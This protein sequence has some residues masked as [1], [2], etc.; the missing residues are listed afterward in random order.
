MCTTLSSPV[1]Y[2]SLAVS[3]PFV[4]FPPSVC[5]ACQSAIRIPYKYK[6]SCSTILLPPVAPA[7]APPPDTG[8]QF[9]W[10]QY[11]VQLCSGGGILK[12][13]PPLSLSPTLH[14]T[15]GV[16]PSPFP[17]PSVVSS[18]SAC[19]PP[20]NGIRPTPSSCV[21]SGLISLTSKS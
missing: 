16:K 5:S 17:V 21:A 15:S 19:G 9:S 4:Y 2:F 12:S 8:P 13:P 7:S 20:C 1:K 11:T 10:S 6:P 3:V 14:P 18:L